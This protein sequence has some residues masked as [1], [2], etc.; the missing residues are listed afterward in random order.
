LHYGRMQWLQI[1]ELA[2][3][4]RCL[5]RGRLLRDDRELVEAVALAN[6]A[7]MS[8]MTSDMERVVS[9]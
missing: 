6:A 7:L 3:R 5:E 9:T 8:Q 1:P 4:T 2:I